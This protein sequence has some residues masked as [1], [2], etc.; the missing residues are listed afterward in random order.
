MIPPRDSCV[1]TL[2][3]N[4]GRMFQKTKQ[5][6]SKGCAMVIL[7]INSYSLLYPSAMLLQSA[8]RVHVIANVNQL[9]PSLP[10]RPAMRAP[11]VRF[12]HESS[13]GA[14]A[15]VST[16]PRA[17]ITAAPIPSSPAFAVRFCFVAWNTSAVFLCSPERCSAA[18]VAFKYP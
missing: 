12:I 13:A 7:G 5:L 6:L 15:F 11:A 8:G 9:E 2:L 10:A 4:V 17:S 16:S 14:V 3:A 18:S 1:A